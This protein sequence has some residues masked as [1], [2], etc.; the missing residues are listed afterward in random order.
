MLKFA[1]SM[2]LAALCAAPALSGAQNTLQTF[3]LPGH[4]HLQLAIPNAW[5][6]EVHQP[7]GQMPPTLE[8]SPRAGEPFHAAL[9][10]VW[11]MPAG[12][13][14]PDLTAIRDQVAAAA[15]A[16]EAQSV[17]KTMLVRE[18]S[19]ASNHGYYFT[20]TDRAPKPGEFK[21]LTQG[22]IRVGAVNLSF[23]VVTNEGQDSVIKSVLEALRGASPR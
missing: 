15:K 10:P 1:R 13:L 2:L 11:P 9:T 6:V 12:A 5:N 23:V 7:P 8:F 20:A 14:L 18:L 21:Y 22:I 3:A 4:G 19:G 17:E 16:A